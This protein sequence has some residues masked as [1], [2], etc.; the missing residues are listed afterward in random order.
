MFSHAPKMNIGAIS[1]E[2]GWQVILKELGKEKLITPLGA[3]HFWRQEKFWLGDTLKTVQTLH[4][5]GYKL[6]IF[7]NSWLG[8]GDEP[9][10]SLLPPELELF[11]HIVDSSKEGLRKPDSSFYERLESRIGATGNSILFIDD[12]VENFPPAEKRGWKTFHFATSESRA[13]NRK[14]RELLLKRTLNK[15]QNVGRK[16]FLAL[17][18]ESIDQ[19]EEYLG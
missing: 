17:G 15:V 18:I 7:T 2:A 13:A 1:P 3:I 10:K 8:L 4:D 6:A 5:K 9:D 16:R 19:A 14:L 12:A 11:E